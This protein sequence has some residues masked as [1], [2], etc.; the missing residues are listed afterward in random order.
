MVTYGILLKAVSLPIY[1]LMK[2]IVGHPY[3]SLH[4]SAPG[5]QPGFCLGRG[6]KIENFCDVTLMTY[7][8]EVIFM[9]SYDVTC[10][11]LKL[12]FVIVSF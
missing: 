2:Q 12:Y 3:S 7:C 4:A 11:F 9:T 5:A 8:A 10:D 1:L 6:L